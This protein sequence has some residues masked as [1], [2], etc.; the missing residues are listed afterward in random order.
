VFFGVGGGDD[1][2]LKIA[3]EAFDFDTVLAERPQIIA[4]RAE[5]YLLARLLQPRAKVSADRA[6][7][8]HED[9]HREC[10]P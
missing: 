10:S 1:G 9:F 6:R 4:A 8:H 5:N 3:L 2:E 7:T